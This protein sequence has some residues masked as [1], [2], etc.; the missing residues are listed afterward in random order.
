V[1][2]AAPSA[3]RSGRPSPTCA[4]DVLA[5]LGG[6]IFAV[7]DGGPCAVGIESTVLDLTRRTPSILRPGVVTR[8]Q[9]E[10]V[11]GT[12]VAVARQ[13]APQPRSP[14]QKYTHYAP[15]TPFLLLLPSA[16]GTRTRSRLKDALHL[17]RDNGQRVALLA[18]EKFSAFPA[19]A[20]FSLGTGTPVEYARLI[21]RG[22]RALDAGGYDAILC[23]GL[24]EEGIGLAVMNRLRKAATTLLDDNG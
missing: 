23:P 1:P 12:H 9:I 22:L 7:V 2:L 14:G 8:E 4:E 15:E 6:S 13:S 10:A 5:E 11:I 20:F 16:N 3:N 24:A 19:D 18:P 17:Y 21:Y